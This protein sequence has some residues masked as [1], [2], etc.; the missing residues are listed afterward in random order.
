MMSYSF[1]VEA[2]TKDEAKAAI[3]A[4]FDEMMVGQPNHSHDREAAINN[5]NAAIDLLID[6]P[7][8]RISVS[9]NGSIGWRLPGD[10]EKKEFIGV[11]ISVSAHLL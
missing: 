9:M 7:S 5:A 11:G 6:D 3:I 10:D 8:K 4:K 2:V 1:N